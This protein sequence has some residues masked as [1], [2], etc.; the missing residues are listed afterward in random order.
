MGTH[1]YS[2]TQHV[3][4]IY[5]DNIDTLALLQRCIRISTIE[6]ILDLRPSRR[7]TAK[8]ISY[9][10]GINSLKVFVQDANI[11]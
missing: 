11:P 3:S 8:T 9:S 6:V 10:Y 7:H 1:N 2:G 5:I 4:L